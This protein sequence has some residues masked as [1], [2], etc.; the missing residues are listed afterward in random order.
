MS[1][2]IEPDDQRI[3]AAAEE[4]RAL[5]PPFHAA[6]SWV[7]DR[8]TEILVI[9]DRHGLDRDALARALHAGGVAQRGDRSR[10]L[11]G[12]IIS[13][14]LST[15]RRAA[16]G[17]REGIDLARVQNAL[18][19]TVAA[20]FPTISRQMAIDAAAE[21]LRLARAPEQVPGTVPASV[22]LPAPAQTPPASNEFQ[23]F[24]A[25]TAAAS[26]PVA[27]PTSAGGLEKLRGAPLDQILTPAKKEPTK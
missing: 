26:T 2:G 11:R 14:A 3:R 20:M 8:A 4:I 1:S 9:R 27:K 15:G 5:Q 6:E 17:R 13:R 7:R 10:A 18:Q 16:A 21:A 19:Q 25:E 23:R 12:T 24:A 22:P